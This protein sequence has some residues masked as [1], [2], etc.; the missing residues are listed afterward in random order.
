MGSRS[1]KT[2]LRSSQATIISVEKDRVVVEISSNTS[3]LKIGERIMATAPSPRKTTVEK[4]HRLT[5]VVISGKILS[6]DGKKIT[7]A[8]SSC[9]PLVAQATLSNAYTHKTPISIK[10]ISPIR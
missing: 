8:S 6:V 3:P 9:Q 1:N 7:V 2:N 10:K 4:H 5:D